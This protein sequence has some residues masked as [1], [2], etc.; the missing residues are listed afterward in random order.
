MICVSF[1]VCLLYCL[2]LLLNCHWTQ[3]NPACFISLY[4]LSKYSL[5]FNMIIFC[6]ISE[7]ANYGKWWI[8]MFVACITHFASPLS[9]FWQFVSDFAFDILAKIFPWQLLSLWQQLYF[10]DFLWVDFV[11]DWKFGLNFFSLVWILDFELLCSLKFMTY[12]FAF[13]FMK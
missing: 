4:S 5:N 9:L 8:K 11:L 13:A 3:S 7:G 2:S 10:L 1:F 12:A 6:T